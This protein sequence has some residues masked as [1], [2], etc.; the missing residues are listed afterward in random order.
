MIN[1]RVEEITYEQIRTAVTLCA[2]AMWLYWSGNRD[3]AKRSLYD[4]RAALDDAIARIQ[5]ESGTR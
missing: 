2:G 1:S 5:I 3:K 4:A